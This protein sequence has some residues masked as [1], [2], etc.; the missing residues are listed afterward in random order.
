MLPPDTAARHRYGAL[1]RTPACPGVFLWDIQDT[2]NV[3]SYHVSITYLQLFVFDEGG[4]GIGDRTE[5]MEMMRI[6][7]LR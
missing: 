3:Y 5:K 4:E 6:M 7:I 2:R 1:P